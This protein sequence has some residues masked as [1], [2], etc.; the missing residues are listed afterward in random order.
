MFR[1]RERLVELGHIEVGVIAD[2]AKPFVPDLPRLADEV[3][4]IVLA[5]QTVGVLMQLQF[6]YV[7]LD[8]NSHFKLFQLVSRG[9]VG[10]VLLPDSVEGHSGVARVERQL[11]A[12]LEL[13][14]RIG[15]NRRRIRTCSPAE[16]LVADALRNLVAESEDCHLARKLKRLRYGLGHVVNI[17]PIR[18]VGQGGLADHINL[19]AVARA[20]LHPLAFFRVILE[21]PLRI[22]GRRVCQRVALV[23]SSCLHVACNIKRQPGGIAFLLDGVRSVTVRNTDAMPSVGDAIDVNIQAVKIKVLLGGCRNHVRVNFRRR[24]RELYLHRIARFPSPLVRI[25]RI[26]NASGVVPQCVAR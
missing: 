13:F 12:G 18:V 26:G 17:A 20:G 16:E 6:I 5:E 8:L 9:R 3:V 24:M 19:R 22:L 11:F 1:I 2:V 21:R 15:G 4:F 25:P 10:G 7:A 23:Q 14:C